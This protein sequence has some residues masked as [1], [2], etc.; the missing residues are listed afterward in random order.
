MPENIGD[1]NAPVKTEDGTEIVLKYTAENVEEMLSGQSTSHPR[2]LGRRRCL[3]QE[4]GKQITAHLEKAD[5]YD[6]K[7]DQHRT[8]AAQLFAQAKE[9]CDEGGFTAFHEKFFPHLGRSRVY[10]LLAIGTGKKSIEDAKHTWEELQ[11]GKPAAKKTAPP[12]SQWTRRGGAGL[13]TDDRSRTGG[14]GDARAAARAHPV[15]GS[16]RRAAG[17]W[18]DC[19][20][21]P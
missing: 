10:D 2:S 20:P 1:K 4:L 12:S 7:A 17:Q 15:G 16:D 21:V 6:E 9:L 3:L 19:L 14:T 13:D 18:Q 5:K 8:A 11:Q